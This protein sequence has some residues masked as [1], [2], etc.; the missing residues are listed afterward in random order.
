MIDTLT[1]LQ[2]GWKWE[3][4]GY[5]SQKVGEVEV[6]LEPL[7]FDGQW[8]LA[9]YKNGNLIGEKVCIKFGYVPEEIG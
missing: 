2:A 5:W 7:I 6:C 1:A 3:E 8:Y 4:P 9:T